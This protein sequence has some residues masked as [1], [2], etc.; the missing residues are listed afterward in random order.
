MICD[1]CQNSLFTLTSYSGCLCPSC[2]EVSVSAAE[3]T[4]GKKTSSVSCA[5]SKLRDVH[6]IIRAFLRIAQRAGQ[7]RWGGRIGAAVATLRR[8]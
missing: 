1:A 3:S 7:R 8:M 5:V 6:C 4:V 2:A